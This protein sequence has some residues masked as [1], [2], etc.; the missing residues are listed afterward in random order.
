MKDFSLK[1]AVKINRG[2]HRDRGLERW[3]IDDQHCD[4]MDRQVTDAPGL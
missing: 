2:L 1:N 3:I 4:A